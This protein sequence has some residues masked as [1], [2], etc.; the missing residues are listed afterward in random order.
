MMKL[1]P[2]ELIVAWIEL[3]GAGA[4][5]H[6]GDDA[7]DADDDAEHGEQ[8][9]HLVARDR[10]QADLVMFQMRMHGT[11]IGHL[12]QLSSTGC[13]REGEG[14]RRLGSPAGRRMRL[15]LDDLLVAPDQAVAHVDDALGVLPRCPA[16]A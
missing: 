7:G 3:R 8:R 4:D 5:G 2:S 12:F 13:D 9:A 1:V 15:R 10:H 14:D 11:F 16:R 6:H